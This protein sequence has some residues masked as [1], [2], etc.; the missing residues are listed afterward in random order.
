MKKTIK[1]IGLFIFVGFYSVEAQEVVKKDT[2]NGTEL[3][4]SMDSKVSDLLTDLEGKCARIKEDEVNKALTK[5][6]TP[7]VEIPKAPKSNAEV[8]RDNPRILGYK[9]QVGVVKSN[10]EANK[11]KTYFRSKFPYMKAETDASL[12]PNYK[13]LAGSYFSKQSASA[14]LARIKSYFPSAIAIQYRVFCVEA[15]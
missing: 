6:T 1:F 2:L 3:T 8:C 12:R 15:K 13:I 4:V 5:T 11:V 9:I 7:K 14:D 10:E